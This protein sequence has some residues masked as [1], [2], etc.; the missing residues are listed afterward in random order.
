MKVAMIMLAA[1]NSRRFGTNKLLH[2]I[3]GIPMY[4]RVLKE[5][6]DAEKFI[7]REWEVSISVVT[8]YK[9]IGRYAKEQGVQVLYNHHPEEGISTSLKIG[10]K[11]NMK[12]ADA[13]LF[14]VSDQPWLTASTLLG[15]IEA[16]VSSGKGIASVSC[17][18]KLGNPCIFSKD[19]YEELM[20]LSGDTGGKRVISAHRGDTEIFQ[21][22]DKKELEDIDFFDGIP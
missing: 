19:Y 22:K 1:G 16:F 7:G 2:E 20:L 8:Q 6:K 5:L 13:C 17:D 12:T 10:L 18:G 11:E 15:L 14:C 9:K 4:R 21:V 3:D